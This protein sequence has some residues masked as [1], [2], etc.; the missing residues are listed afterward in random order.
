MIAAVVL[1]L[2]MNALIFIGIPFLSAATAEKPGDLYEGFVSFNVEKTK[3]KEEERK[4]EKQKEEE[5]PEKLPEMK[6][7]YTTNQPSKPRLDN[8]LPNMN[9]D[10]NAS[11]SEGMAVSM[12]RSGY[13]LPPQQIKTEFDISE[14]DTPPQVIFRTNPVYPYAAK[15]RQIHG[16]VEL[17][18]LVDE[19]GGV[20]RM[21][22]IS[23]NPQGVFDESVLN[24]IKRWKFKPGI[25]E[26]RAVKTWVIAPFEF[27]M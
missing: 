12:P 14:V 25:F 24:A 20:S 7:K 23:S 21:S 11:L 6:V 18:F 27:R 13:A 22:I 19:E 9:F 16:K 10:I 5:K 17:K 26:G 1:A 8:V 2:V 4:P 3:P 15:R